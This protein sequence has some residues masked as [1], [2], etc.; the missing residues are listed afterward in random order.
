MFDDP[1]GEWSICEWRYGHETRRRFATREAAIWTAAVSN[2]EGVEYG[3]W[4][5]LHV[6]RPD[7]SI[8]EEAAPLWEYAR[9]EDPPMPEQI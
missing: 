7:D 5:V 8:D 1:E 4:A 9:S 6:H 3:R 2:D